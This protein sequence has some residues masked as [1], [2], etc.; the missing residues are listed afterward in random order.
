MFCT[1]AL[2]QTARVCEKCSAEEAAI[3]YAKSLAPRLTCSLALNGETECYSPQKTVTFVDANSGQSYKYEVFRD[4]APPYAVHVKRVPL[5]RESEAS[6]KTLMQ[7]IVDAN[8]AISNASTRFDA[9]VN[10]ASDE[11]QQ[12]SA[13]GESQPATECPSS[14]ALSTLVNPNTLDT[15]QSRAAIE[16]GAKLE[17][18][19]DYSQLNFAKVGHQW[20]I[21]FNGLNSTIVTE[22]HHRNKLFIVTFGQSERQSDR[23]DFFAYSV[24]IIG[25]DSQHIPIVDL[26]LSDA[27]RVAGYSLGALKGANG[28]LEIIDECILTQFANAV[29]QGVLVSLAS[30]NASSPEF[31][32]RCTTS[33]LAYWGNEIRQNNQAFLF[34]VCD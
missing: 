34:R 13:I 32:A 26:T 11:F 20:S 14:S 29:E 25:F 10:S 17:N 2:S 1:G 19:D 24:D 23:K 22:G 6:F 4:S 21:D 9:L 15:I 18:I 7:F 31:Q 12:V 27:S 28:P 30:S 33:E 5:S 8:A 3:S 16:I